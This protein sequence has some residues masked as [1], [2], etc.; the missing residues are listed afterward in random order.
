LRGMADL[1]GILTSKYLGPVSFT[2]TTTTKGNI[3]TA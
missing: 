3:L 1:S 2:M